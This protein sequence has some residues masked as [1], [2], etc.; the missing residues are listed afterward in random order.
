MHMPNPNGPSTT[1]CNRYQEE[2]E[3][4]KLV[5]GLLHARACQTVSLPYLYR[6]AVYSVV[7]A[8]HNFICTLASVGRSRRSVNAAQL[9][10]SHSS[11][12]VVSEASGLEREMLV[13]F[14]HGNPISQDQPAKP[15]SWTRIDVAGFSRPYRV[16]SAPPAN[17]NRRFRAVRAELCQSICRAR[18]GCLDYRAANPQQLRRGRPQLDYGGGTI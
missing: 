6:S 10:C 5:W 3:T 18:H 9:I 12:I 8:S 14:G 2:K 13:A 4:R 7:T 11:S 15:Y 1:K 16:V 17:K